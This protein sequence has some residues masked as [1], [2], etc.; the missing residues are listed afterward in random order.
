[1][2]VRELLSRVDSRELA[3]WAA[4][5]DLDP[6]GD[7]DG[8]R[9]RADH[10]AGVLAATVANSQPHKGRPFKPTDFIP[11]RPP[12]HPPP[13]RTD[14]DLQRLAIKANA[15]LCGTTVKG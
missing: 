2:T 10:R 6:W 12:R 5:Y 13:E 1:M 14:D 8:E 7:E 9:D 11:K 4:Y 15:L 3:E